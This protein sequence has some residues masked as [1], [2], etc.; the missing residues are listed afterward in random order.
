MLRL[1]NLEEIQSLLLRIP[2]LVNLQDQ[3]DYRF[4]QNVKEWLSKC[5]KVLENNR[6]PAAGN[7]A[8]LRAL[9]ISAE[10]GV[11]PTE[12]EFHGPSNRR[13]IR[14]SVAAYVLRQTGSLISEVINKDKERI[15]EAQRIGRQLI[16]LA[17]AKGLI[18]EFPSGANHTQMLKAIWGT[19][20]S[21][22]DVLPGTVNVEGL[23]GPDDA[24]IILDRTIAAD[25]GR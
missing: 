11:I 5:E 2:D 12:V 15:A 14:E 18:H 25:M 8:A 17:K 24:L 4:E 23:V 13:K 21:D 19:L 7:V 22:P 1:V 6:L 16:A 3:R 10:R 9:L 20:A